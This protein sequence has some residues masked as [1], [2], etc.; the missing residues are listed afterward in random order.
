MICFNFQILYAFSIFSMLAKFHD[1][2]SEYPLALTCYIG[3]IGFQTL[4][5]FLSKTSSLSESAITDSVLIS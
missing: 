3:C 1:L 2:K 4:F 5:E